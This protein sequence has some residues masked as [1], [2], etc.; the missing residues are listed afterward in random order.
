MLSG[1]VAVIAVG[2]ATEVEMKER[3]H[4]V[5]DAYEATKAAIAEGILP[6]GGVALL[7]IARNMIPSDTG[8]IIILNAIS[9]PVRVLLENSGLDP[10]EILRNPDFSWGQINRGFNVMTGK[11]GDMFEMGIVDPAKVVI[12][13]LTNSLSVAVMVLTTD[14]LVAKDP[15][16]KE[17]VTV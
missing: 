3:K 17:K 5:V 6:G 16:A 13:A 11:F 4:R 10:E 14:A 8:S 7:T 15:D 1:K 9:S 2:G 12:E